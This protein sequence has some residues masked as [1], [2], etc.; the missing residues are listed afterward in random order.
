MESFG[1]PGFHYHV[2]M[3]KVWAL[4]AASLIE[5]PVIALNATDFAHGLMSYHSILSKIA[6]NSSNPSIRALS[7]FAGL[8]Q[9]IEALIAATIA[10]DAHAAVLASSSD[11]DIPWWK[12]WRKIQLYFEIKTI[13]G[14]YK[15]FERQFLYAEG[16][17]GWP[18]CARVFVGLC[19]GH[20]PRSEGERR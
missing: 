7:H 20:V 1:D 13:N 19:R 16:L 18:F 6:H 12:W 2:T 5:S 17:D 10:F 3:A 8:R 15:Y 4:L 11:E 14:K 9:A